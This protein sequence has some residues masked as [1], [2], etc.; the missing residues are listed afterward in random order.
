VAAFLRQ[1]V[2]WFRRR[3]VR[4]QRVLTDNGTG[5]RSRVLAA[6]TRAQRLVHRRARPYT[7]R[8][9]GNAERFIRTLLREWAYGLAFPSSA[10]RTAA[11]GRWLHYYNWHRRHRGLGG[12]PPISRLVSRDD[13]LRHPS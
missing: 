12:D 9:N 8:T 6:A 13:L 4:V 2:R 5:Y 3:G 1:A 7:P 10:H 11:L